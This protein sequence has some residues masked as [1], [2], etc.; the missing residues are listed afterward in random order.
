MRFEIYRDEA[1]FCKWRWR[2]IDDDLKTVDKG[3][4]SYST[5]EDCQKVVC[6]LQ[7]TKDIVEGKDNSI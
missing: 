7:E 1:N 5:M 4:K 6:L 3:E 2:L